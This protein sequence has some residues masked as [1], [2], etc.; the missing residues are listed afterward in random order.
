MLIEKSIVEIIIKIRIK[1]TSVIVLTAAKKGIY[2]ATGIPSH[3]IR[4]NQLIFLN[5]NFLNPFI[6]NRDDTSLKDTYG[7]LPR[8]REGIM[9]SACLNNKKGDVLLSFLNEYK[10]I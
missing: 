8:I 5:I 4:Y 2:D 10:S 7:D 3:K 6:N 1:D 9:Y